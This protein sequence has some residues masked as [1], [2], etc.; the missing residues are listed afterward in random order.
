M[1]QGDVDKIKYLMAAI[2]ESKN[3]VVPLPTKYF[4]T[5]RTAALFINKYSDIFSFYGI[6]SI[7]PKS[8]YLHKTI[9]FTSYKYVD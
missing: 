7:P 5:P 3:W 4:N 8:F 1:E 6:S 2:V 9:I